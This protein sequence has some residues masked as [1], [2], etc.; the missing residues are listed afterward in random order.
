LTAE[1]EDKSA[2]AASNESRD[3]AAAVRYPAILDSESLE[4]RFQS[5]LDYDGFA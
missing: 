2:I 3:T 4:V 5:Q 1:S